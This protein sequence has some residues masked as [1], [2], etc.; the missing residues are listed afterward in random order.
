MAGSYQLPLDL[1][2]YLQYQSSKVCL[3]FRSSFALLSSENMKICL[4]RI[5]QVSQTTRDKVDTLV[6]RVQSLQVNIE[7]NERQSILTWL[8]SLDFIA[9]QHNLSTRRQAD[10]GIWLFEDEDFQRWRTIAGETL[11]CRGMPG[12]GQYR[13]VAV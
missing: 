4:S 1:Y 13:L 8:S 7:Q 2:E 11:V 12:A 9:Q 10:T 3:L 6:E 5:S